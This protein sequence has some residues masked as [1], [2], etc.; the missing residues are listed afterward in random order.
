MMSGKPDRSDELI[1]VIRQGFEML[2]E[3]LDA[4]EDSNK[5][6]FEF[7]NREFSGALKMSMKFERENAKQIISSHKKKMDISISS[8]KLDIE[9]I[10]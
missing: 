4:L 3:K 5:R 8:L 6:G 2:G 7:L 10:H 9:T 1:D